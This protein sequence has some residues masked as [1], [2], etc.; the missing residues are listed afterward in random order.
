M[1]NSNNNTPAYDWSSY[2]LDDKDGSPGF[3]DLADTPFE[4]FDKVTRSIAKDKGQLRMVLDSG[5]ADFVLVPTKGRTVTVL[6]SPF[7]AFPASRAP[8]LVGVVG[9][10][11]DSP[12]L[13]VPASQVVKLIKHPKPG[14]IIMPGGFDGVKTAEEFKNLEGPHASGPGFIDEHPN[15][16]FL[17]PS[18]FLIY[19]SMEGTVRPGDLAVKIIEHCCRN[20]GIG[21]ERSPGKDT[22]KKNSRRKK[23]ED[24]RSLTGHAHGVLHF[25]WKLANS[26][27]G[28]VN[29][30]DPP[31]HESVVSEMDSRAE[32]LKE[33]IEIGRQKVEEENLGRKPPARDRSAIQDGSKVSAESPEESPEPEEKERS[34]PEGKARFSFQERAPAVASI[35]RKAKPSSPPD[36]DQSRPSSDES[37][38]ERTSRK[39]ARGVA[40]LPQ[41]KL[42]RKVP[43]EPPPRKREEQRTRRK[44]GASRRSNLDDY[45]SESN[46]DDRKHG[47]DKTDAE[48]IVPP[49]DDRRAVDP[50]AGTGGRGPGIG[51]HRT[52]TKMTIG[53][54]PRG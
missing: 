45:H 12:F 22:K 24:E 33:W 44:G 43:K 6:H 21:Q 7:L 50:L 52:D 5:G 10:K 18:I 32:A 3:N 38:P 48:T 27:G 46:S 29:L 47:G 20:P 30:K 13:A 11:Q 19:I 2:Y 37:V 34:P 8:T 17:H 9:M 4:F 40:K 23:K 54:E 39:K 51:E 26:T 35:R 16:F 25:L 49:N 15:C 31:D 42:G 41:P 53:T 28:A 14:M 1:A 36:D